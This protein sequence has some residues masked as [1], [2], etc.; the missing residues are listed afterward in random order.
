MPGRGL[1]V[2]RIHDALPSRVGWAGVESALAACTRTTVVFPN[3][4]LEGL[5]P[6]CECQCIRCTFGMGHGEWRIWS[7]RSLCRLIALSYYVARRKM[8]AACQ[9]G[10]MGDLV[11]L[12][13]PIKST[14]VDVGAPNQEHLR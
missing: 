1:R 14:C 11:K 6:M 7:H 13:H 3:R 5:A 4:V 8:G 9:M 12:A 2:P 10:R